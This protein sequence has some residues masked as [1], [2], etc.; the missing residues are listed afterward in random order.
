MHKKRP[1]SHSAQSGLFFAC[2]TVGVLATVQHDYASVNDVIVS[3]AHSL[4]TDLVVTSQVA[5]NHTGCG[6]IIDSSVSSDIEVASAFDFRH[7]TIKLL[8]TV[9]P[10]VSRVVTVV[11][12]GLWPW[13]R[14]WFWPWARTGARLWIRPWLMVGPV[15]RLPAVWRRGLTL[16]HSTEKW[17]SDKSCC[18]GK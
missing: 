5:G 3:K 15:S 2:S 9:I 18:C 1:D 13:F 14:Q 8:E 17:C 12:S 7:R 6:D 4:N 11:S 10:I 16:C